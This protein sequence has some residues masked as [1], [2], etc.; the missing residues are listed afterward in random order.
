MKRDTLKE[1][2]ILLHEEKV[3]LFRCPQFCYREPFQ[4]REV[5][6]LDL[7]VMES[8][9][10]RQ[11][12]THSKKVVPGQEHQFTIFE[13]LDVKRR[14]FFKVK[15]LKVANPI[16]LKGELNDNLLRMV[17]NDILSEAAF[18]YV[19]GCPGDLARLQ[20]MFSLLDDPPLQKTTVE[21]ILVAAKASVLDKGVIQPGSYCVSRWQQI[22]G[23]DACDI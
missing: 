2:R 22:D 9:V 6:T 12:L 19:G 17:A 4:C 11:L 7:I 15:A 5:V 8:L 10:F 1:L 3:L 20:I 16:V 23:G 21:F 13:R 14:R 18:V